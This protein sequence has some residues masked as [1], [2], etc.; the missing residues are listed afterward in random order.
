MEKSFD[1]FSDED[2]EEGCDR[3]Q[4]GPAP[5]GV[6]DP[7]DAPRHWLDAD[8]ARRALADGIEAF[9][10]AAIAALNAGAAPPSLACRVTAGTGKT[11]STLRAIAGRAPELLAHGSVLVFAPGH[12]HA[13]E[14]LAAFRK[15]APNVPSGAVRGRGA[16]DPEDGA[17]MCQRAEEAATLGRL[18][19]SVLPALCELPRPNGETE[20]APCRAG[21]RYFA[22]FEGAARVIFL[23]HDYLVNE[24][25]ALGPIALR[26][27]DEAFHHKLNY[28]SSLALMGWLDGPEPTSDQLS[29]APALAAIDAARMEVMRALRADASPIAK[30]RA[31]GLDHAALGAFIRIEENAIAVPGIRPAQSDAERRKRL[32]AL[33]VVE[34][35]AA[36]ARARIWRILRDALDHDT[37]ERLSLRSQVKAGGETS[38]AIAF[39]A[40][41]ELPLDAP[42]LM[43]DA[44]ND[45]TITR[46]F[47]PD[48]QF[49]RIDARPVADVI[50][51]SNRTL[52]QSWLLD[53]GV[54]AERRRQVARVIAR[55]VAR[56]TGD[57]LLVATQK[58]LEALHRDHDPAFPTDDQNALARPLLGATPQWFGPNLRGVD[59]FKSFETVI[60]VGRLEPGM[61]DVEDAMRAI[62]G[63]DDTPLSLLP[64]EDGRISAVHT[65][66]AERVMADG[67]AS[68][69]KLSSHPDPRGRALLAQIREGATHQA[70]ARLRLVSPDRPKRVLIL[71][72]V[73]LPDIPV[74]RL[75]TWD[76]LI[77]RRLHDAMVK[78]D[79]TLRRT[80]LRLSAAGLAADLPEAFKSEATAKGWQRGRSP[81]DVED[82]C[83]T[84]AASIGATVEFVMVR[85]EGQSG[86]ATPAA[87]FKEAG[88][89]SRADRA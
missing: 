45:P 87:V 69:V 52:S 16:P 36:R 2:M 22:Q 23:A 82:Q 79:G 38:L 50:Q 24:P 77:A 28:T 73:P 14:T 1:A 11:A 60:T 74:T 26:V 19:V 37:T 61:A 15:I 62:F 33:N 32:D 54:G 84:I 68:P 64:R 53:A 30:L 75:T 34:N 5:V 35:F 55:E 43:L 39:H 56:A 67:S 65:I 10:D 80:Q 7:V 8:T 31:R 48:A 13:D 59:R 66:D 63:D 25:A 89:G 18:G 49:L 57:V 76:D 9:I 86:C 46:V 78:A 21:C 85:A 44:E 40:R 47:A 42:L 58:V 17:P 70:I 41:K 20:R 3:A 71:S 51:L 88:P 81:A 72:S 83:R 29:K 12:A 27:I 4:S 6:V